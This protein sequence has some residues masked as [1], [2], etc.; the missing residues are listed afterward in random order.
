MKAGIALKLFLAI[1]AARAASP[2]RRW[3]SPRG[4]SFQ[5][6][7]LGYLDQVD[8]Q[9]LDALAGRLADEYRRAGDWDFVRD[10]YARLR[11]ARAAGAADPAP[12]APR[13]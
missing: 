11:D 12:C 3:R 7:F 5:S 9:R 10:D 13:C 2:R 4:S 6:G 8:A 1:L